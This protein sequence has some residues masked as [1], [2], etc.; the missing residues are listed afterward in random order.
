MAARKKKTTKRGYRQ[1]SGMLVTKLSGEC[2]GCGRKY[3]KDIDEAWGAVAFGSTEKAGCTH[4]LC[5]DCFYVI[6]RVV[7]E[8]FD[9]LRAQH[10]ARTEGTPKILN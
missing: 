5:P 1:E 2:D 9:G 7:H 4:S 8:M 6:F 10:V 3:K